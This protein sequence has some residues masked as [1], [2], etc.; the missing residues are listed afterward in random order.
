MEEFNRE[1][2]IRQTLSFDG[3]TE[4]SPGLIQYDVQEDYLLLTSGAR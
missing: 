3:C 1:V 2:L 4:V